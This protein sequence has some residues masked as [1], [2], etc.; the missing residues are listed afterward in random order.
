MKIAAVLA[1]LLLAEPEGTERDR[2]I[3]VFSKTGGFRHAS[4][5]DGI[6]AVQRLGSQNGFAVDASED[7]SFFDD[8]HLARFDAVVFLCTTGDILD[9]SQK[10]AFQRFI[11]GGRGF[12]GVHSASDTEYGWPWYGALVGAYFKNH[13]ALAP[14]T[15]QVID[16]VHPS[17]RG[18]PP[19]WSRADEWYNFATNPRPRA[20]VLATL[21]EGTYTGG[22]MG[23]DHPIVW[24]QF[25]D[26]GRSWYTALGHTSESY[27]EPLFLQH[28][29]GGIQFAA[30]YPDADCR[31]PRPLPPR[32][33]S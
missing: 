7:S 13:P 32:R 21:D 6:A 5:P 19:R 15:I 2:R 11:E 30:G 16:P 26:G 33:Q 8:A 4:I 24:C 20:H 3:L 18:L 31:T 28:L 22:E 27:A 23:S 12:V 14:A 9:D 29:L 17:T 10:A 1:L 25:Y